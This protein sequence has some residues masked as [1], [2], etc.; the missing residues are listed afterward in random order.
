VTGISASAIEQLLYARGSYVDRDRVVTAARDDDMS[1]PLGRLGELE[2]LRSYGALVLL[3]HWVGAAPTLGDVVSYP[4]R[5]TDIPSTSTKTFMSIRS[6]ASAD[7]SSR[8]PSAS[9]TGATRIMPVPQH[10]HPVA[11]HRSQRTR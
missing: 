11:A 2:V 9:T 1:P 5:Q 6:R 7:A 4:T 10:R 8:I 3:E